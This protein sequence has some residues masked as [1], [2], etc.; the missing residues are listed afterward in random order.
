MQFQI[1]PENRF[2]PPLQSKKLTEMKIESI[3]IAAL[4]A[5]GQIF[6]A[7][8][9]Q[10]QP[11]PPILRLGI[12]E[13]FAI[14]DENNS[15]IK[16]FGYAESAA[17][18]A[19]RTARN[20]RLPS[21]ELSA[22]ASYLGDAWISDR[23]FTNGMNAPMPHFGNNF[24]IEAAYVVYA[25]GAVSNSIAMARL[26]LK[27]MQAES[28]AN[29]QNVRLLIVGS[30]LELCKLDN[31][32]EVL[33]KNIEQT[34]RLL[35]D[36]RARHNEGLAIRNDVTRY[37]L[38]LQRLELALTQTLNS[39]TIV[40]DRLATAI[41][42][43]DGTRIEPLHDIAE[44]LPEAS[45]EAEW[46]MVSEESPVLRRARYGVEQ[47]KLGVKLAAAERIPSLTLFAGD[48][49][50]GPITIEVP[51][52]NRNLNYWYVGA[53]LKFNIASL[54]KSG[55]N[56]RRAKYESLRA[57]ALEQ[58]TEENLHTDVKEAYIRLCEAFTVCEMYEKSLELATQNYE[59]VHNRFL[60]DL[61]LIADM[62]DADSAKL[63]A[64]LDVANARI[65][66][67]FNYY[68]LRKAAG[69]L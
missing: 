60:N 3:V 2:S 50:D 29:R 9:Q 1:P 56:I 31:A 22:S 61:A 58:Q 10:T 24:A 59:V 6:S 57:E 30:Y 13:M 53:G 63:S 62:L 66:I 28:E 69:N 20:D 5:G 47:S 25:G 39:R 12:D 45:S 42:V 64:E 26:Q 68:R 17:A 15:S 52:L 32:A 35:A 41:G 4:F 36:I 11:E 49:L 46:Q 21:V 34:R 8:A 48:H 19:A 16:S 33:D 54:Y 23:N 51:P 7:S 43:G 65:G 44:R 38:Q 18:E 67:L 40:N 55:R 27:S 14:A 37:E